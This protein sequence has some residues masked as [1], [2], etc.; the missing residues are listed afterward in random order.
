MEERL[1]EKRKKRREE[2][3]RGRREGEREREIEGGQRGSGRE[4]E[5]RGGGGQTGRGTGKERRAN[6]STFYLG[7]IARGL[8]STNSHKP[9]PRQIRGNH[10][11]KS[12]YTFPF[13]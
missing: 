4:R 5:R 13:A 10:Q 8:N 9:L 7:V 1:T 3:E 11:I 2:R 6:R 12:T